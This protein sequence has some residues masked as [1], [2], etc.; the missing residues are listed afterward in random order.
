MKTIYEENLTAKQL[1]LLDIVFKC[2]ERRKEE[3]APIT[4]ETAPLADMD[5]PF[6]KLQNNILE[7]WFQ[8]FEKLEDEILEE[9]TTNSINTKKSKIIC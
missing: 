3:F 8:R 4:K 6:V 7:E 1:K 2:I 9:I 5:A